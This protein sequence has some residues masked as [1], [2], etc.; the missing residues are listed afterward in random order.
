[1]PVAMRTLLLRLLSSLCRA[2]GER[3]RSLA[4][5]V[6]AITA[7]L[8]ASLEKAVAG[9]PQDDSPWAEFGVSV[10]ALSDTVFVAASR[11][12]DGQRDPG[13][14]H[15]FE[16]QR[17]R[18]VN[19][20]VLSV[21][22][23][24][25]EDGFGVSMAAEGGTLVVG[26]QF[27]DARGEDAGVAYV[28]ER[29]TEGWHQATVLSASDGVPGDQFGQTVSVSGETI[30][31]GAR[32]SDSRAADAGATYVFARRDG[33]WQEV[34]KVMASAAAAGDIF[35]RVSLDKDLMVVSA[36]LNDDL[37]FNAGKA[38]V[39]ERREGVWVEGAVLTARDGTA[40]DEFGV[41]LALK[42]GIAVF[43]AVGSDGRDADAGAAYVF[44][45]RSGQWAQTAK[46]TASDSARRQLFGKFV[47][48]GPDTVVVGAPN[49]SGEGEGAG[50]AYVFERRAE[51][52]TE[53]SKL[54]ASDAA[55]RTGFGNAV[56]ISGSTIVVGMLFN[57]KG[58]RSG[59]A[60]VFE[61]LGGVWSEVARLEPDLTT[62]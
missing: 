55:P 43:G 62:R 7:V 14:V 60:Y 20:G 24:R 57:G 40:G 5:L 37:G 58:Q 50:A 16:R 17:S 23:A 35:G 21:P 6:V 36:D 2:I 61:R 42:D 34:G 54:T 47:A 11:M 39:F 3:R 26:A 15:V 49:D 12:R 8:P 45:R 29:R 32:L 38:Y 1:M 28:F 59:A 27:A 52:W 53:V 10:A 30:A 25:A 22:E 56:A 48:V 18:W 46:L 44:E 31:V 9:T 51:A 19:V 4:P 33:R 13:T 41:S